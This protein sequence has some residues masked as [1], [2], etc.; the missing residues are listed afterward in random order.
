MLPLAINASICGVTRAAIEEAPVH[1]PVAGPMRIS[2]GFGNRTDPFT[3]RLAFHPGI[4]FPWPTGTT[5]MAAGDG[6]VIYV[7]Q[8]NGYGNVVDIDHGGGIVTRYG[9][10]SAFLVSKGEEVDTG[11][12]IGRVGSTGRSTG[13][14]LHFEVRRD[15]SPVNPTP[16]LDLGRRLAHFVTPATAETAAPTVDNSSVGDSDLG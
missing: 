3:G 7:G 10:L 6:K 13:P 4:D 14:H 16:Y 2:S 1:L 12:P 11:T 9:H 8:I 15:D 5:V